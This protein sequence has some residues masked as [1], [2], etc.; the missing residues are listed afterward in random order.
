[1]K[2]KLIYIYPRFAYLLSCPPVRIMFFSHLKLVLYMYIFLGKMEAAHEDQFFY[3]ESKEKLHE[4]H[5]KQEL[6]EKDKKKGKNVK[7]PSKP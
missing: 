4:M 5:E 1:M 7:K 2:R 3:N 6:Q